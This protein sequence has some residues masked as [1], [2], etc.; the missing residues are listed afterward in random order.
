MKTI[1]AQ[2]GNM[3]K[4]PAQNSRLQAVFNK[5]AELY[6][7]RGV[8][9]SESYLRLEANLSGNTQTINFTVLDTQGTSKNVTERRLKIND[10]FTVL[11]MGFYIGI[12]PGGVTAAALTK[13]VL[14]TFPNKYVVTSAEAAALQS[15]YNG[16]INFVIDSTTFWD[17]IPVS[18]FYRVGTAQE[19]YGA[20]AAFNTMPRSEWSDSMYGL[21]EQVPSIELNGGSNFTLAINLPSS[22]DLTV[23]TNGATAVIYFQGFLHSGAKDV[24]RLVAAELDQQFK[25][26]TAQQYLRKRAR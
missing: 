10:T 25:Q 6:S 13:M 18:K 14:H 20:T 21:T 19:G 15:L 17:S 9:T 8:I 11:G 3:V 22:T 4:L 7:K 1:K 26:Q 24:Q 12:S 2:G 16:Y 5:K 23:A